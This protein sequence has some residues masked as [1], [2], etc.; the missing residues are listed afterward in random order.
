MLFNTWAV[1]FIFNKIYLKQRSAII[2]SGY[3]RNLTSQEFS[4]VPD[5][6]TKLMHTKKT[7]T[8]PHIVPHAG[9]S[10]NKLNINMI[11]NAATA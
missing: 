7:Y 2:I 4:T 10:I 8:I 6:I 11:D 5:M 3:C 9:I 1:L